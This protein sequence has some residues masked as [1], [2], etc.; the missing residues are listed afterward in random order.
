M[1]RKLSVHFFVRERE[2]LT[3]G[4]LIAPIHVLVA[5]TYTIHTFREVRKL[6]REPHPSTPR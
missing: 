6:K 4:T 1:H 2:G 3:S 5:C